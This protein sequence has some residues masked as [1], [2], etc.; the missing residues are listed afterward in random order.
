MH[1]TCTCTIMMN[2]QIRILL[3]ILFFLAPLAGCKPAST[4]D[5]SKQAT[6]AAAQ[7]TVYALQTSLAGKPTKTR[8]PIPP[9]PVTPTSTI[10]RTPSPVKTSTRLPTVATVWNTCDVATFISETISDTIVIEPGSSFIK[11][12][13]IQNSGTCAWDKGYKLV[14]ESGEAM[15]E[16][17]EM[18]FITGKKK[19]EPGQEV[20]ISMD[21]VSP[22]EPGNYLGFW[23]L[24]NDKGYRFGLGGEG[25]AIWV[26]ITVGTATNELFKVASVKGFAVPNNF[27]GNCGKDGYTI[28]LMGKIKTNRAGTV[29]YRWKGTDGSSSSKIETIIFYGA[30]TQNVFHTF[31]IAKGYHRGYGILEILTPNVMQ[32]EKAIFN[33]E[34][35]N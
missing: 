7:L 13:T 35:T 16:K 23:K 20:T 19:V 21:L 3:A 29:T 2:R 8:T 25:N 33:V 32:S 10:T 11:T 27:R 4:E 12:W 17:L 28:T 14:F 30:D 22:M 15:T 26:E 31:K 5:A 1:K 24:A 9:T 18:S 34:C 6:K